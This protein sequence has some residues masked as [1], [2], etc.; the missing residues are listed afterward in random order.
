M[1]PVCGNKLVHDGQNIPFETFLGFNAEKVPDIDLNFPG[2]YQA[3]AHEYTKVLLGENNVFRAGTIETVADKTAFGFA[4]GYIERKGLDLESYPKVKIAFLFN[5]VEII[6]GYNHDDMVEKEFK[7]KY[8]TKVGPSYKIS[9][10]IKSRV[11]FK[12]HNLLKD[13]Y[14]KDLPMIVCRNVLIYFTEEAKDEVF[15][16]FHGCLLSKGILFIGSTE[17]IIN[18]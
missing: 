16:K 8:F 7:K 10:E 6:Q 3:R 9:D 2:D 5:K 14:P 12:Q 1:C 18:Y 15:R 17:Q 11:E 4:R 13:P